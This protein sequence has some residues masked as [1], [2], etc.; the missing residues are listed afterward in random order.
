M[1]ERLFRSRQNR[2][3]G[4]VAAGFAEYLNIDIILV[5]VIFVILTIINGIG[6]LLYIIL[7]IVVPEDKTLQPVTEVK[8]D[9]KP[10]DTK[11]S[12]TTSNDKEAAKDASTAEV[13][14]MVPVKPG[15]KRGG[16][17]FGII[18]I[19]IGFLFLLDR[20]FPYFDFL[21]LLP[22]VLIGLGLFMLFNS[23]RQKEKI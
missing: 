12:K 3:I 5:R 16:L 1:K 21:D 9:S 6:L 23:V 11:K 17:Y 2:V 4:G 19:F 22:I 8:I 20:Y 18:L 7:W 15:S 14:T 10:K 13:Q